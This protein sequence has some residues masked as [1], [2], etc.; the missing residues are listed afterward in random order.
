[1][2]RPGMGEA[3]ERN[4]TRSRDPVLRTADFTAATL[5]SSKPRVSLAFSAGFRCDSLLLVRIPNPKT[6]RLS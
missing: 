1:M 4:G 3:T 2:C 5:W 6:S